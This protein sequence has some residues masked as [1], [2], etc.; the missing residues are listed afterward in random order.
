[1]SP[2]ASLPAR[3]FAWIV[4]SAF[5]AGSAKS[6]TWHD[7][8]FTSE[9]AS[10]AGTLYFPDSE[11]PSAAVVLLH[12]S[13]RKDSL[14]MNALANAL[15]NDGFAVLTYDKRGLGQSE[16]VFQDGDNEAAFTLLATDA[17]AAVDA[18]ATTPKLRGVPVGLLGIS[19]GGWIGPMAATRSK[20]IAF[21]LLW[22]GPV[23]TLS[24][25]VHFS[26]FSKNI[27][28]FSMHDYS[29]EV[30]E[31]MRAAPK[32]A[33]GFDPIPVLLHVSVSTLWVFGARDNSIPVELSIKRL[34][35][36]IKGG[37]GNFEYR[38]LPDG[39]HE[40]N[41]PDQAILDWM[42]KQAARHAAALD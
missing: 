14:R 22:S 9:G 28:N 4:T 11:A 5:V 38:L 8:E 15:A 7:V 31:H 20:R 41:Y 17:L 2:E 23:C 42:R 36:L 24:E 6:S 16:G 25:E 3:I 12:G 35:G 29:S 10:L 21:M 34:D 37:K 40:L 1:M 13:A 39:G 33:S 27:P 32:R 18:I 30:R 19:Q 26:A